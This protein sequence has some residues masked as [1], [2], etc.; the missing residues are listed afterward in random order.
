MKKRLT[1]K[2]DEALIIR[3]KQYAK[4]TDKSLSAIVENYLLTLIET[5]NNEEISTKLR[6]LM[7]IVKLPKKFDYKKERQKNLLKKYGL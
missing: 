3:A 6:S 4:S 2:L 5:K 7:G 1:I